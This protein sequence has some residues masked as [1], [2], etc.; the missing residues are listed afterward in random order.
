MPRTQIFGDQVDDTTI[1]RVDLNFETAGQAV[2]RKIIAGT[3]VTISEDGVDAGTGDVTINSEADA[4]QR[5]TST[6]A[7]KVPGAGDSYL[8]HD[9]QIAHSNVPIILTDTFELQEATISVNVIDTNEYTLRIYDISGTPT[10]IAS[11][12]VLTA[13]S[14]KAVATGL[15]INLPADDYGLILERTAGSGSSTFDNVVATILIERQ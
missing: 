10:L 11:L 13:S 1:T 14:L 12:V 6:L 2:T 5:I 15:T 8:T 9:G 4:V 7:N 3:G